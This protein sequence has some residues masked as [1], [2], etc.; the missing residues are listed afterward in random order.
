M[1]FVFLLSKRT[2]L[3]NT[4][5]QQGFQDHVR[6]LGQKYM[7]MGVKDTPPVAQFVDA[8]GATDLPLGNYMNVQYFADISLGTPAQNFKVVLD[9]GSSNLWVPGSECNS[10]AC[11]LHTKY[12][13]SASSSYKKNG[14]EFEIAY[15]SGSV[16][17]YISQDTLT[18]GDLTIPKQDFGEATSEPGLAFAFGKFDG[19]LGLGFDTIAVNKVVPPFYNALADGLLD[20]PVFSFKLG[21]SESSDSLFTLGGVDES[22]YTGKVTYLPVRRKAYWEVQFDAIS[23]GDETAELENTGAV[24]DTGTSLITLPSALA[25]MINAQIGAKKG[26]NGQYSVECD[27]K[28]SLPPLTFNLDGYNFTLSADDYILEVSGSCISAITPFDFPEP[29]GPLS[30]VGD[31]FLRKYYSI[32]DYGNTAVGLAKAA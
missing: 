32:Y 2:A 21:D 6:A 16:S 22:A 28:S 26:W 12:D 31:A 7:G 14:S 20:E 23:L 5:S 3:S 19:I 29:I 30:I 13:S 15:G 25:E 9:T 11:F 1:C 27:T 18:I 4:V 8:N 24:I 10:I 17:G